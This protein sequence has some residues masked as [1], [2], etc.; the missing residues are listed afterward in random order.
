MAELLDVGEVER[1][2]PTG[3]FYRDGALVRTWQRKG[4][5][6]TVALLNVFAYLANEKN[7]HPDLTAHDYNQLTVRV[8]TH[9][10]GGVTDLDLELAETFNGIVG[11]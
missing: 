3:W 7:H 4:W 8:T 1:K 5:L 6:N 2:C 9:Y 10:K 11:E